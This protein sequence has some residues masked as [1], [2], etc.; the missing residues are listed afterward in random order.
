MKV[1]NSIKTIRDYEKFLRARGFSRNESKILVKGWKELEQIK[2][3][4]LWKR[5]DNKS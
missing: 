3:Q 1:R 5:L 2:S 4:E